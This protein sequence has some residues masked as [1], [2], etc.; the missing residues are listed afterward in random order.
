MGAPVT[1]SSQPSSFRHA[2]LAVSLTIFTAGMPSGLKSAGRRLAGRV[3]Q[4]L[5]ERR[6]RLDPD[7][8]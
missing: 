8:R 7:M 2:V 1:D 3:L 6:A 4:A 5:D